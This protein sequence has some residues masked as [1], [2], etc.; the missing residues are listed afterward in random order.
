MI[1][2]A[3]AAPSVST[4]YASILLPAMEQ[5]APALHSFSSTSTGALVGVVSVS[6][7]VAPSKNTTGDVQAVKDA[8]KAG[9]TRFDGQKI[10]KSKL[11]FSASIMKLEEPKAR[12]KQSKHSARCTV[13]VL[14]RD[15]K[16]GVI[17]AIAEGQ[18]SAESMVAMPE[19]RRAAVEGAVSAAMDKMPLALAS[20]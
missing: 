12:G 10:S 5:I 11:I 16:T 6:P 14:A 17:L 20:R 2:F 13:S 18:G 9:L 1:A 7:A 3:A 8:M 15:A 19:L 4:A